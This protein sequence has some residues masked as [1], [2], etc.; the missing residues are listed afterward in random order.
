MFVKLSGRLRINTASLNA[1]G[2]VGNVIELAKA[3]MIFKD[4]DRYELFEVPVI[5]GNTLKHWH[6]VHF[7]E[8]YNSLGGKQLC[9]Y[10]SRLIGFR[11]PDTNGKN[12]AYFVEKCAG[13]DLHGFLQPEKQVR[14]DSLVKASFIIPVE[15]F[16]CRID[17][18]THNRV[19]VDEQGRIQAEIGNQK[20][21]MVFKRQ[22]ASSLYGFMLNMDLDYIG[23]SLFSARRQKVIKDNQEIQRRGKAALL[24]LLPLLSGQMGASRSRAEPVW[25]VEELMAAACE[26]PFP[27]LTHAHFSDYFFE[28]VQ[29]LLSFSRLLN[30]TV[31]VYVYGISEDALWKELD[32]IMKAYGCQIKN[33]EKKSNAIE[34]SID[35]NLKLLLLRSWQDLIYKLVRDYESSCR[36]N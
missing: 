17:T 34:L 32:T 33:Y 15:D 4:D 23:R 27:S 14:R 31:N 18:L 28:S 21:M 3:H 2:T 5:T 9:G 6:F 10:C 25:K 35:S 22:Y 11:S 7:I 26:G 8:A 12:E 30:K 19:V 29:T 13:E 1:Q 16:E 20:A 36:S 24:A